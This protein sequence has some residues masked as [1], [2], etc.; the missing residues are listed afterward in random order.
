MNF[1][2]KKNYKVHCIAHTS[3][4]GYWRQRVDVRL[5]NHKPLAVKDKAGKPPVELE[6]SKSVKYIFLQFSD[7][8]GWL[9]P[10]G[11][12]LPSLSSTR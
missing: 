10:K 7:I 11:S 3:F 2:F 12:W 4:R 9:Q 1:S 8:V 6:V 5:G